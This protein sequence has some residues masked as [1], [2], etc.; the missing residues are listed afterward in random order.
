[1]GIIVDFIAYITSFCLGLCDW[2]GASVLRNDLFFTDPHFDE[3]RALKCEELMLSDIPFNHASFWT[4]VNVSRR[5]ELEGVSNG[6]A[7]AVFELSGPSPAASVLQFDES[8]VFRAQIVVPGTCSDA[9]DLGDLEV[10]SLLCKPILQVAILLPATGD[11]GFGTRRKE[12]AIPLCTHV[13]NAAFTACVMLQAPFY[14]QRRPKMWKGKTSLPT[15][16]ALFAQSTGIVVEARMLAAMCMDL[17]GMR[18]VAFAGSSY[19]GAMATLAGLTYHRNAG[20]CSRCG[21][22]SPMVPFTSHKSVLSTGVDWSVQDRANLLKMLSPM[23]VFALLEFA[24]SRKTRRVGIFLD[25]RHDHFVLKEPAEAL[26]RGFSMAENSVVL[27]RLQL[28]GGHGTALFGYFSSHKT[29]ISS[30]RRVLECIE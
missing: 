12:L 26:V 14:G 15:V 8:S 18:R 22:D 1:M 9:E 25:A 6:L 28:I 7:Y 30:I 19:G 5:H 2:L 27:D 17:L 13:S 3:L 10:L 16:D 21:C 20:V 11:V 24:N 4:S 23:S 29:F